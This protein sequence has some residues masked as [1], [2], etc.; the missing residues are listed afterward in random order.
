MIAADYHLHSAFSSDS[1]TLL[2]EQVKAAI[3]GGRLKRLCITDHMDFDFPENEYGYTFQFDMEEYLKEI[4]RIKELYKGK[5]RLCTG[6][7]LGIL[8]HLG[9]K[10]KHYMDK[11]GD[12]LDFV[13]ASSHLVDGMDPYEPIYFDTY[14][15][16]TGIRKYLESIIENIDVF[17]DFDVYGHLDYVVRYAP[18]KDKY[19]NP[20]DYI[21]Y[22]D[23]I[24]KKLIE[25]NK[26]I[27]LNTAGLK[28]GLSFA[29]PHPLILKRY[30][31]LG[32][33]IITVG[34]DA[35]SPERLA[36]CFDRVPHILT[37]AGFKY[38]TIFENR[39]PEFISIK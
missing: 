6:V 18:E 29:H 3:S 11:Y 8:P 7:E 33:E 31:E 13:I 15:T 4:N 20:L 37:D 24:L 14:D 9:P 28:A 16:K 38:Y 12:K 23:E 39:T 25:N 10:L 22:F 30:R 26:G 27:E 34:S 5:I 32:G 19:Y 17:N 21:D 35:H 36:Y 1:S 2:D